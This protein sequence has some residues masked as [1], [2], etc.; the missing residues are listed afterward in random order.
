MRS[1]FPVPAAILCL[2]LGACFAGG[3]VPPP[4][5]PDEYRPFFDL[6]RRERVREFA[7]FPIERQVDYYLVGV[8]YREP[9]EPGLNLVIARQGPAAIPA[10]LRRLKAAQDV[11]E[12]TALISVFE[13]MARLYYSLK[14]E[15]EVIATIR[16]VVSA[17]PESTSKRR[18]QE[19][20][21]IISTR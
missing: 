16:D 14:D 1:T 2:A 3:C 15:A 19:A 9:P 6:P 17:M 12:Q 4:Q 21:V 20:L 5:V 7:N 18:N 11:G 13:I 8:M 10:L